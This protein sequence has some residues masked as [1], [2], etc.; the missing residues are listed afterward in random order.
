MDGSQVSNPYLSG[1][2]APVVSEDDF[3]LE[4]VGEIPAAISGA[5]YR[6]GPN[7]QFEPRGQYHWFTGDGMIH[8]VFVEGGKAR[9]RNRYV[10]TP[11]WRLENAAGRA[12]FSGFDPRDVD[13]SVVGKNAGTANTNIVWHA[14]RLLALVEAQKPFELD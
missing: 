7:P 9:Y 5:F 2:F 8:G 12:L 4:V 1:N 3:E 11:K 14:G 13:P 10:R 6:N